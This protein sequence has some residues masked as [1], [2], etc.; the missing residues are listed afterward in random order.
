MQKILLLLA[1]AIVAASAASAAK[2]CVQV[3]YYCSDSPSYRTI[4]SGM[5]CWCMVAGSWS[6]SGANWGG[7]GLD[8]DTS[9]C[10]EYCS[11]VCGA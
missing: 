2:V 11:Y 3:G 8:Y 4:A 1:A 6:H 5:Y 7:Y 9:T 10:I